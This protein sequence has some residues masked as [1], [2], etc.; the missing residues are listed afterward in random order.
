MLLSKS[1][2]ANFANMS[3]QILWTWTNGWGR[4]SGI[5]SINYGEKMQISTNDKKKK[6]NA[7]FVKLDGKKRI[8][9]NNRGK[10]SQKLPKD[11]RNT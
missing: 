5:S 10:L 8:L 1:K 6:K 4:K 3:L 2:F 9:I 11:C 7:I